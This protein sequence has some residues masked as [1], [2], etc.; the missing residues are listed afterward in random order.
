MSELEHII[1]AAKSGRAACKTCR[2][3]IGKGELRFGEAFVNTFSS[4]GRISH[5]WHHL[6]CA[7]KKL[8]KLLGP[9]LDT[10]PEPIEN[11]EALKKIIEEAKAKEK[12]SGNAAFPYA[13]HAPTGRA[14]CIVCDEKIEKGAVRIAI[15]REIDTGSF[16]RKG[17]GYMHAHCVKEWGEEEDVALEDFKTD[18]ESNTKV[19]EGDELVAVLE[20]IA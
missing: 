14:R 6:E 15:E 8:G 7:A 9:V 1:E 18:L 3:K 19:I 4:S 11:K 10:Y 13:D 16:V 12:S 20:S 2:E 17:P 5:R